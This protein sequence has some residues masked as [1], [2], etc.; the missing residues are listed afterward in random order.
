MLIEMHASIRSEIHLNV[1]TYVCRFRYTILHT[2]NSTPMGYN[3]LTCL[4]ACMYVHMYYKFGVLRGCMGMYVLM[5]LENKT[6][7]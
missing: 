6:H 3:E 4:R 2:V 7:C 1:Y 5:Y